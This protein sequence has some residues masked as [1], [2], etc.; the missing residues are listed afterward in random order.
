[1]SYSLSSTNTVNFRDCLG[2]N[3]TGAVAFYSFLPPSSVLLRK[4]GP[5]ASKDASMELQSVRAERF[6]PGNRVSFCFPCLFYNHVES[7]SY[8]ICLEIHIAAEKVR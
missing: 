3:L 5:L 4:S 7:E 6:S 8:N 2:Q 1:M